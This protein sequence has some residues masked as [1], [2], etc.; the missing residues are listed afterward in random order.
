MRVSWKFI[1]KDGPPQEFTG[2]YSVD[3][4]V[5]ALE[6]RDGGSLIGEIAPR[7]GKAFNFKL[8]G[9]PPDDQGL[10]FRT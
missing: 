2:T 1:P 10:E 4:N 6:R 9:A 7:E 5:L 8:L 3:G